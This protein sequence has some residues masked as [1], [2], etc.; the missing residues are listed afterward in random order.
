LFLGVFKARKRHSTSS[1]HLCIIPFIS[2]RLKL[3]IAKTHSNNIYEA[4]LLQ[5]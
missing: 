1:M 3:Y 5:I 2:T 4:R